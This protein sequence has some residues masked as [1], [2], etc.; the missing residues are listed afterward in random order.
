[1][2]GMVDLPRDELGR[3]HA[4]LLDVLTGRSGTAYVIWLK[5]QPKTFTAGVQ[6]A[7]LDLFRVQE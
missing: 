4:R 7:A 3:L 6:H 5:A 2:T 1:M